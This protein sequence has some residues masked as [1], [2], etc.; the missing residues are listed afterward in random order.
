MRMHC[1]PCMTI[2]RLHSL[3]AADTLWREHIY[4]CPNPYCGHTFVTRSEVARTLTP[5]K[6]PNPDVHI[7]ISARAAKRRE[8]KKKREAM[9]TNSRQLVV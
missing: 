2:A 7:P 8:N 1:P 5:S 9:S 4:Y 3:Y 6:I